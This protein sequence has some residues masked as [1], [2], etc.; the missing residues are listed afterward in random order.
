MQQSATTPRETFLVYILQNPGYRRISLI[1]FYIGKMSWSVTVGRNTRQ[2]IRLL[3]FSI[4]LPLCPHS[5]SGHWARVPYPELAKRKS[6]MK[7]EEWIS[8]FESE[9]GFGETRNRGPD[10]R[11]WSQQPKTAPGRFGHKSHWLRFI[12]T[13]YFGLGLCDLALFGE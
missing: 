13:Y 7:S 2:R 8:D 3:K 4:W 9:L 6:I 1:G 5:L 10:R 12:T 11:C